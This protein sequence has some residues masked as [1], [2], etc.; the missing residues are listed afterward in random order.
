M[1]KLIP[2]LGLLIL[3]AWG[4]GKSEKKEETQKVE[5]ATDKKIVARVNGRPI[6][7]SALK[8]RP[9]EEVIDY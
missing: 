7:E 8:V 4:C 5:T 2:L 3:I 6:Y 1:K 9:L